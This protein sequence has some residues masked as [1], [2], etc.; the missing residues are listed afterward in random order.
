MSKKERGK[1]MVSSAKSKK[2]DFEMEEDGKMRAS[3]PMARARKR[4]ARARKRE[5][6]LGF[7]LES[8]RK[9]ISRGGREG[10]GFI[11]CE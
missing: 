2:D 1:A 3:S 11:A 4:A 5:E 7:Y 8:S 9:V 10:D 6:R